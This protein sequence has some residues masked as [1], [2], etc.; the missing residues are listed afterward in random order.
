MSCIIFSTFRKQLHI[1]DSIAAKLYLHIPFPCINN[2]IL[3]Y[4]YTARQF[5]Q[6]HLIIKVFTSSYHKS[7]DPICISFHIF[8]LPYLHINIINLCNSSG[9]LQND[10]SSSFPQLYF[11][12]SGQK[13]IKCRKTLY[14]FSRW[15]SVNQVLITLAGC[16]Q[17]SAKMFIA[18]SV[19]VC[20]LRFQ[21]S[22][23]PPKSDRTGK[24]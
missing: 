21:L 23:I 15:H 1:L 22:Y 11:P 8:H 18:T 6:L 13:L 14:P 17:Y 2:H 24:P 3:Q 5:G 19:A 10:N 9:P 4:I 16:I 20:K 12:H 7:Q